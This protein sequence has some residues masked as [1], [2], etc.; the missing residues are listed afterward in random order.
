MMLYTSVEQQPEPQQEDS[1]VSLSWRAMAL[2]FSRTISFIFSVVSMMYIILILRYYD[3]WSQ[4]KCGGLAAA[5]VGAF[6]GGEEG[7]DVFLVEGPSLRFDAVAY[8]GGF[9]GPLDQA[10]VL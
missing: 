9:D 10:A 6:V 4:K 5:V 2:Y 8:A 1:L 7:A 3:A